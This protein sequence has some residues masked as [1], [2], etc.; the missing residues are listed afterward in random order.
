[1]GKRRYSAVISWIKPSGDAFS[2]RFA[3][4]VVKRPFR[5]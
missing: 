1:M 2:C 4:V 5:Q 3:G